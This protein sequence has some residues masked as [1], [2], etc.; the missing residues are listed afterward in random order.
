MVWGEVL[1]GL[2][3]FSRGL[4]GK[5]RFGRGVLVVSLWWI[6]GGSV[7]FR[8]VSFRSEKYANFFGFILGQRR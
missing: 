7:V 5:W 2:L 1:V 3:V 8:R 4:W 6:D